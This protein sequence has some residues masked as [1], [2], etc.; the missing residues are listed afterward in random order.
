[1]DSPTLF[2]L[3]RFARYWDMIANSGRF[4]HSLAIILADNPFN[5][6]MALTDFL[7]HTTAQTHRIALPRLFRLLFEFADHLE[8]FK[9][10]LGK[11]FE[12]TGI[13]NSF[14]SVIGD[15][16]QNQKTLPTASL[17]QRRHIK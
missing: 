8:G 5:N 7:F 4:S 9:L 17:R 2:R 1:M 13:K 6:F 10:A 15:H 11:D 3:N 12:D 14:S 16:P